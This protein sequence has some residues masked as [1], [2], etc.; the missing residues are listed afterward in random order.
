MHLNTPKS[1]DKHEPDSPSINDVQVQKRNTP[2]PNTNNWPSLSDMT[3][4]KKKEPSSLPLFEKKKLPKAKVNLKQ[5]TT[6]TIEKKATSG[7]AWGG[8]GVSREQPII[9]PS[10]KPSLLDVMNEEMKSLSVTEN[11]GK[12]PV[13]TSL[14][15]GKIK[16]SPLTAPTTENKTFKGWNTSNKETSYSSLPC[17]IANIIE[18]EKRSKDQYKKLTNRPLNAI[19]LEEAA[20]DRLLKYY[21]VENQFDI[22]IKI[23]L[24]DEADF[25]DCAP[26]WKNV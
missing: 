26:I 9:S 15:K 3:V 18:M 4:V 13:K 22:T 14:K 17:S 12:T 25:K 23:E 5:Q 21:D 20:I 10:S 11:Q 6:P 19:Q 8:M 2:E 1:L 7:P 24:L 16:F